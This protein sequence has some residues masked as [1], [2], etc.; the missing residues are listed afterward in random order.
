MKKIQ[1]FTIWKDGNSYEVDTFMLRLVKDDLATSALF[2][3]EL[4]KSVSQEERDGG[5]PIYGAGT[6]IANGNVALTGEDYKNWGST[7]DINK[8]SFEYAASKLKL[9]LV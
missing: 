5:V 3:Y 1:P 2:Y 6:V 7:G 4:S 8:E 9:T